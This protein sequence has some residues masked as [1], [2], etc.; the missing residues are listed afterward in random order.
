MEADQEVA[1]CVFVGTWQRT[2]RYR[3][4][5]GQERAGD[6]QRASASIGGTGVFLQDDY[7][8]AQQMLGR[9]VLGEDSV[10]VRTSGRGCQ[11]CC[12]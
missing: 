11:H 2:N 9:D 12:T 6:V 5:G 1:N 8:R 4:S 10:G 3:N 7:V